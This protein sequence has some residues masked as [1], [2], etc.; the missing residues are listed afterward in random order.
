M[1][2]RNRNSRKHRLTPEK[3]RGSF[4]CVLPTRCVPDR[5]EQTHGLKRQSKPLRYIFLYGI[6]GFYLPYG[7]KPDFAPAKLQPAFP[8]PMPYC[9]VFRKAK[10]FPGRHTDKKPLT[11]ANQLLP[12]IF[13]KLH[14]KVHPPSKPISS[15]QAIQ[16]GNRTASSLSM[17]YQKTVTPSPGL[18]PFPRS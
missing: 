10:K 13:G 5:R 9:D 6:P 16:P 17:Q 1:A 2:L 14:C 18:P 4:L 15:H 3:H 7:I 8:H 12:H 11:T